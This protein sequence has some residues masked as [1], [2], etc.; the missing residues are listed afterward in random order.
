MTLVFF[1]GQII[2]ETTDLER[3]LGEHSDYSWVKG[4]LVFHNRTVK[5]RSL[6]QVVRVLADSVTVITGK[7]YLREG[8]RSGVFPTL[9]MTTQW[10]WLR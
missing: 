1:D 10:L 8:K 9:H 5:E 4:K 6:I 3:K 2:A 7:G